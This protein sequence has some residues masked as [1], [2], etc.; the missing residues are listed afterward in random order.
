MSDDE[1]DIR[2]IK[3]LRTLG[4]ITESGPQLETV[5]VGELT[6]HEIDVFMLSLSREYRQLA[7]FVRATAAEP[8][9]AVTL[10]VGWVKKLWA[11]FGELGAIQQLA[12][13]PVHSDY[14]YLLPFHI[15][16]RRAAV[17]K[18]NK[19]R[20]GHEPGQVFLDRNAR[21]I[22]MKKANAAFARA[23]KR[24]NLH[25][26]ITLETIARTV[27]KSWLDEV[28]AIKTKSYPEILLE[29]YIRD[30]LLG[31]RPQT[32]GVSGTHH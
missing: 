31:P 21:A 29:H 22:T 7:I 6:L 12:R 16:G 2:H 9:I 28:V 32:R 14:Q 23:S 5:E 20:E 25:A 8:K 26:P 19:I 13:V 4:Y 3:P 15:R 24:M 10:E 1:R 18:R 30:I 11:R 17:L 27:I